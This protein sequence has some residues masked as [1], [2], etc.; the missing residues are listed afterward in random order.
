MKKNFKVTIRTPDELIFESKEVKELNISTETGPT[1]I[2]AH[3]ASLTGSILFSR[4]SIKTKDTEE[5]FLSRR[6]TLFI[7]NHK[8]EVILLV[9]SCEKT[10]TITFEKAEQYLAY[11]EEL[12]QIGED[13]SKVKLSYLSKEKLAIEEQVEEMKKDK[14]K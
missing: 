1:T 11:I 6:G 7:D 4:L 14:K 5:Q 13:L 10:A 8:N 2:Y 9:V 3:H 12:I